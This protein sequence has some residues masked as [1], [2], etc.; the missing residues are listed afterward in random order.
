MVRDLSIYV[1]VAIPDN[2]QYYLVESLCSDV[3]PSI[4]LLQ[5]TTKSFHGNYSCKG[6]NLAGW[7]T[8][9]EKTELAV[10]CEFSVARSKL[11]H[12]TMNT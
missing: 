4:L 7:G 12:L 5:D 3:E 1:L 10:N 2:S 6:K 8:E 11:I 9:S